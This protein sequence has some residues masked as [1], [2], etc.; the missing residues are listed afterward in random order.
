ME[1]EIDPLARVGTSNMGE[2][3]HVGAFAI[4][5]A[6]VSLGARVV[7]EPHATVAAGA[8]IGDDC[9]I[10]IGAV[11]AEN[12]HVGAASS[13]GHHSVVQANSEIE[14]GCKIDEYCNIGAPGPRASAPLHLGRRSRV[15]SHSVLYAGSRIGNDLETGHHV[16]V[17][18]HTQVGENLRVGNFSDIEGD[19]SIGDYCR[20]HGYVHVGKGSRIGN[21][22][23]LFSLTTLTNDPLPPS[24]LRSPVV[25]EDGA[26]VCVGVTAMPGARI[27]RGALIS[28]GATVHG[29][30]ATG[31]VISGD[32]GAAIAHVSR[33]MHLES[34]TR[35][36]WMRHFADAYP[37]A[38]QDRLRALLE[39]IESSRPAASKAK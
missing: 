35:H 4:V 23:W 21:F 15:R 20:F 2:G 22:V 19:C 29:D 24:S 10:G 28:A 31:A 11:I 5:S 6:G 33:L 36:P 38:A 9:N 25:V 13:I 27:G 32:E 18:E 16:V 30:V 1:V 3:T 7:I 34:G 8:T 17:R 12:A 37:A 26:V 14:D 39:E